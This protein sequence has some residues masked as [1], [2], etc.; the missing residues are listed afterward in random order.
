MIEGFLVEHR[1]G[2]NVDRRLRT[3]DALEEF[4]AVGVT[5]AVTD[6]L[7]IL[8]ETRQLRVLQAGEC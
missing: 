8:H 7:P 1:V 3:G 6:D 4:A 2:A 5:R